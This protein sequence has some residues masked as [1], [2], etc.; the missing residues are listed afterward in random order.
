[1]KKEKISSVKNYQSLTK[2]LSFL[3]HSTF[4]ILNFSAFAI[5]HFI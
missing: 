3:L 1:M 5:E 2:A 4:F